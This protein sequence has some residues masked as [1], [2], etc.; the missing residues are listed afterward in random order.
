MTTEAVNEILQ[1]IV[2]LPRLEL[3][4]FEQIALKHEE[5]ASP[6]IAHQLVKKGLVETYTETTPGR[7]DLIVRHFRVPDH[8]YTVWQAWASG[9]LRE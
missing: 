1:R 3:E 5:Y 6:S 7:L 9:R 4:A 8:I 2:L